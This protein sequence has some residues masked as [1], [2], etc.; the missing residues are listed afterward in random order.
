[1]VNKIKFLIAGLF[2]SVLYTNAQ[3]NT[4][5]PYSRFGLGE[6]VQPGFAPN[7]ALGGTGIANRSSGTINYLN[8]A[9]LTAIDS[10][11]FL[12]D[13]GLNYSN[14]RYRS[15]DYKTKLDNFNIDH[16]AIGFPVT[17]WWKSSVAV[18]PFSRV[19]YTIKEANL[20]PSIG[21]TDY[22]YEGSGGISK[23]LIGNGFN[24]GKEFSVGLNFNYLFGN[25]NHLQRVNFPADPY[26]AATYT[27]NN[28]RVEGMV[29]N[30]GVQYRKEIMEKYFVTLG[31][32]YDNKAKLKGINNFSQ[33]V[34]FPGAA[35]STPDSVVV[36][37]NY[38]LDS[39]TINGRV[40][41]PRRI[42]FGLSLGIKDKLTLSGDYSTQEW[43][44]ALVM[45]A[46]DSL[47]DS[48][49]VNVGLEYI[50]GNKGSIKKYYGRVSYR[51]GGYYTNSYLV[52][53]GNQLKDYGITFGAG[54]PFRNTKTSLNLGLVLG[55]RGTLEKGLI[56]ENYMIFNVSL[57]FHDLWFFK[58]VI[59]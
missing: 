7:L 12:F 37:P 55:Q 34:Y 24:I 42:G 13:F 10:M 18:M 14:V 21:L 46:S 51:L 15:D 50:P 32:I 39:D 48:K 29:F 28:L 58:T 53:R 45:G 22:Y 56:K 17:K 31:A 25:L 44:K 47:K 16:V 4:A 35:A 6:L 30:F 23:I 57:T 49:S 33:N 52:L 9:S 59:D 36:N 2:L 38:T 26:A 8:P 54:L 19:G 20:L 41:Y 27:Q 1:M 40:T 5:S 11:S 3:L 43:S